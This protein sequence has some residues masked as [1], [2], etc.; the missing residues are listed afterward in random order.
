MNTN[1]P[2][3]AASK[4]AA[5]NE[6]N[7]RVGELLHRI[8][9]DVK[10]IARNEVD[11]ARIEIESTAKSAAADAAIILLGGIVA[12]IG[13]GL[14][15]VVAVVALEPLI[16]PLWLRLLIMAVVY[17]AIGGIVAG[18]FAKRL[19]EDVK[20]DLDLPK[21]EAQQTVDAIKDGLRAP[22]LKG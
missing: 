13:L 5:S 1:Q 10:T 16:S 20:P 3:L 11:L 4:P 6:S 12:L 14:L 9:D 18:V 17:L 8:T 22:A 15:C 7:G 2:K 21:R 19:K